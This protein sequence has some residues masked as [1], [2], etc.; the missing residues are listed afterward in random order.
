MAHFKVEGGRK[1]KGDLIPQGAK[2]EA[3]QVISGVLLSEKKVT[4]EFFELC[5]PRPLYLQDELFLYRN[6]SPHVFVF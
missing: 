1:L 3:L 2:N 4:K 6:D 5:S